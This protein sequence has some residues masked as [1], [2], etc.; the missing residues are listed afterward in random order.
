MNILKGSLKPAH[1]GYIF[2]DAITAYCLL[3]LV[4]GKYDKV[5][6][7]SK[8]VEDDRF[9]DLELTKDGKKTRIQ[10]KSSLDDETIPNSV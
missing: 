8:K 3:N 4:L 10:I 6:V 9:D 5:T 2:Q 7:D 1:A